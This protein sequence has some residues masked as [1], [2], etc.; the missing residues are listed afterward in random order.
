MNGGLTHDQVLNL[1]KGDY[2]IETQKDKNKRLSRVPER[3]R[4]KRMFTSIQELIHEHRQ[5]MIKA[6]TLS[7]SER[8]MIMQ[9]VGWLKQWSADKLNYHIIIY[10][11]DV[12]GTITSYLRHL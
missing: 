3:I 12:D 9:R 7:K 11:Y 5:V 8:E 6:S 1:P 2:R 4:H 10:P